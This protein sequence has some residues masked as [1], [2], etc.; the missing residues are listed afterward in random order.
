[1]AKVGGIIHMLLPRNLNRGSAKNRHNSFFYVDTG[2]DLRAT[3]PQDI[4]GDERDAQPDLGADE[5]VP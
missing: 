1:M 5:L 2:L 3:C 4:D